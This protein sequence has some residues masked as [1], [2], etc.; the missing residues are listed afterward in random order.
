MNSYLPI[1]LDNSSQ[2]IIG[3]VGHFLISKVAVEFFREKS[4][5]IWNKQ[6][7]IFRTWD[8]SRK[9]TFGHLVEGGLVAF[10]A[11]RI[12]DIFDV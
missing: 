2:R 12:Q 1:T 9:L 4:I 10:A 7:F 3:G 5:F 8:L 11:E 6:W